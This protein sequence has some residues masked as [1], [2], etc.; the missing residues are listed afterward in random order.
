[1]YL[2]GEREKGFG[3]ALNHCGRRPG[4]QHEDSIGCEA[5][6]AGNSLGEIKIEPLA[7]LLG[8]GGRHDRGEKS[9]THD[10]DTDRPGL[11]PVDEAAEIGPAA[12]AMVLMRT[13]A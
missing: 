8:R 1:M 4:K 10:V 6:H 2:D 12:R 9:A 5:P 3:A 13:I 11:V 7:S